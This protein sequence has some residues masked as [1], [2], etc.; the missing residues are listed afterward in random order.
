[1]GPEAPEQGSVALK[2]TFPSLGG[3]STKGEKQYPGRTA[4]W[5]REGDLNRSRGLG[6][7]EEHNE[8]IF[9]EKVD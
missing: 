3:K 4:A 5:K 1:V 8:R 2:I 7:K 6:V 9:D